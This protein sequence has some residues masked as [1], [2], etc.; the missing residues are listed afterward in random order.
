MSRKSEATETF[1]KKK[2][3]T[4]GEGAKRPEA[5]VSKRS[6]MSRKSEAIEM[7]QE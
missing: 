2:I 7:F 5:A 1:Q 4:A 6:R 3:T